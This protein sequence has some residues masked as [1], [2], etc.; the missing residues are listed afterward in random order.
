MDTW[1][2]GQPTVRSGG[3]VDMKTVAIIG[4]K[5]R[6]GKIDRR[7]ASRRLR[8]AGGVFSTAILDMDPSGSAHRWFERR[9]A[10][11]PRSR[12]RLD[13]DASPSCRGQLPRTESACC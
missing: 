12:E 1:P 2:S 13:A 11:T 9:E 10:P 6:V 3:I 8:G 7:P 5:G 4:Q